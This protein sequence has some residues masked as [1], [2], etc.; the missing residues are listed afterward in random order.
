MALDTSGARSAV[1][2]SAQGGGGKPVT[3]N[4]L[5]GSTQVKRRF[6]ELL[7]A[8]AP[9]FMSSLLNVVKESPQL[10]ACNPNEVLATAAI[11]AAMDLPI[12]P[13]LGF[14]YIVPYNGRPQFQMGYR[15]YIQLA[16]RT[17]QYKTIN[18]AEVFEGE[19]LTLNRFTD[20]IELNPDGRTSD[21]VVGYIAYFQLLNGFEKFDYMTV[22][23]VKAHASRFSQAYRSGKGS[24]W[25]TDFDAM[26]TKTVL[27]RLLSKYG[28]LSIDMQQAVRADQAVVVEDSDDGEVEF[29]YVDVGDGVDVAAD[30]AAD[31]SGVGEEVP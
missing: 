13:N 12:D 4:V 2:K 19:I 31:V 24:T 27:K 26:A 22:A 30:V 16:L 1:Q 28:I 20:A 8:R 23:E 9:G 15:G 14:A 21:V 11:A 6:E 17:G 29:D 25:T 3:L 5:M 7:G 18:A 10:Q